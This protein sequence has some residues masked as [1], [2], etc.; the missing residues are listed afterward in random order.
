[1]KRFIALLFL[2]PLLL[3]AQTEWS[4]NG[5][6]I[7]NRPMLATVGLEGIFPSLKSVGYGEIS[8]YGILASARIPLPGVTLVLEVP[9]ASGTQK[10]S[11]PSFTMEQSKSAI[12]NPY[13]GVEIGSSDLV[14]EFGIRFP[15]MTQENGAAAAAVANADFLNLERYLPKAMSLEAALSVNPGVA[16]LVNL[17]FRAGPV[18][19]IPIPREGRETE[20]LLDYE[21]GVAVGIGPLSVAAGIA[22]RLIL[23]E[24]RL[25]GQRKTAHTFQG[26]IAS[27]FG[28]VHPS[29]FYRVPLGQEEISDL[30]SSIIGIVVVVSL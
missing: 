28:P 26:E 12:G 11:S 5:G 19:W 9:F 13:V 22:G 15:L 23:T 2:F 24:D 17:H 30:V 3:S 16:N 6:S 1:M 4:R 21:A 18:L 8:G 7:L 27:S 14:T 20:A 25:L 29:L 10:Y